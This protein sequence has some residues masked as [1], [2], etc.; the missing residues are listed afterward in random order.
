MID[1]DR[2]SQDFDKN[3]I[4]FE[5]RNNREFDYIGLKQ[6][7]D[8]QV[9]NNSLIKIGFQIRR[10]SADYDY[11]RWYNFGNKNFNPYDVI[12]IDV[13]KKGTESGLYFSNKFRINPSLNAEL[14]L[15]YDHF[16]WTGDDNLSPRVNLAYN[17]GE[18]TVIR[19]GW[20]KFYQAQGIHLMNVMDG[21]NTYYPAE[22]SKH[23]VAGM[24]HKYRNGINLR[25]ELY[26][27]SLKNIRPWYYKLGHNIDFT[28]ETCPTRVRVAPENGE[29]NGFEFYLFKNNS[30]KH[31]WWFNYTNSYVNEYV[32]GKKV[33]R[34]F[35]QPHNI[36][37]DY[38]YTL[39]DKWAFFVAWKYHSGW[40]YT[41]MDIN[42]T[43]KSPE[44]YYYW[45]WATK[46]L[47]SLRY[48]AYHR[49]DIRINKYFSTS[50]GRITLFFE[51]R[52]LYDRENVRQY[53]Y[54]IQHLNSE[55]NYSLGKSEGNWTSRFP[56][57]GF[58]IDF[59]K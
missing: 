10:F 15:R 40:P 58:S 55:Y 45:E 29:S 2:L 54:Y 24:E 6:D 7:W 28:P 53:V 18:N 31:N 30:G 48:P 39:N 34:N 35:D 13:Y 26:V 21:E 1:Q 5:S 46:S 33:P 43:G 11:F 36:N 42:F 20:G 56:L 41:E 51:I 4:G 27:K 37:F 22:L 3:K 52:N 38:S 14:G 23:L 8:F 50:L 19:A 9:S 32:D 59:N 44:G 49:M 16:S 57:F 25:L 12:D 47:N 17:V